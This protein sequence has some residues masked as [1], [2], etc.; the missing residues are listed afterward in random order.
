MSDDDEVGYG[1]P[2]KHSQFKKG[3]SG[4]PK[5]RPKGSKN[6]KTDFAEVS[7]ERVFVVE[8]GVRKA[9]TKQRASIKALFANAMNGDVP[10]EKEIARQSNDDQG[11]ANA[12]GEPLADDDLA[13]IESFT[14][15]S[16]ESEKAV[17]EQQ[18]SKDDG[19]SNTQAA[20]FEEDSNE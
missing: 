2:P 20:P 13:I 18:N 11:Q 3:Q 4:N 12:D 5:G 16:A 6:F 1:K 15:Q 17:K 8:G 7:Q 14:K 19:E 10:A 9:V